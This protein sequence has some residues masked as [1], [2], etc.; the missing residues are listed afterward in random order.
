[1]TTN[2]RLLE[3][4]FGVFPPR[5]LSIL[6]DSEYV[7][8]I[9][10]K[11]RIRYIISEIVVVLRANDIEG[12]NGL[13]L[14]PVN[15]FRIALSKIQSTP[16]TVKIVL[17]IL[18]PIIIL[19][20]L[21]FMLGKLFS[22]IKK[23]NKIFD[24]GYGYVNPLWGQYNIL[25][26]KNKG[27]KKSYSKSFFDCIVTHEFA[28][29]MQQHDRLS[30]NKLYKFKEFQDCN[31]DVIV[32]Q[33][34]CNDRHTRYL[35]ELVEVEARLHEI[36]VSGYTNFGFLPVTKQE[37]FDY[38]IHN[39]TVLC[40]FSDMQLISI[41]HDRLYDLRCDIIDLYN[42]EMFRA[43]V[44]DTI[45]MRFIQEVLFR[46]YSNLLR[47]YGDKEKSLKIYNSCDQNGLYKDIYGDW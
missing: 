5:P 13:S 14:N 16:L 23:L 46:L 12:D 24:N 28:H 2:R 45:R 21:P 44:D 32:G 8:N 7:V 6:N 1:M 29:V 25:I 19:F 39:K 9:K 35:F 37:F 31:F 10:V 27:F 42:F 26:K 30:Q 4:D 17:V 33:D 40:S 11:N 41:K 20:M 38:I 3:Q 22:S 34:Y 18:L 15:E 43:L 36:I 47:Y